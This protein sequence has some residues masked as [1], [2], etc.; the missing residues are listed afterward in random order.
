MNAMT[1]IKIDKNVPLVRH[2]GD[3]TRKYPFPD[4]EIGDSICIPHE[5]G[6]GARTAAANWGKYNGRKF[7][8][9]TTPEGLR[10]WR[11]A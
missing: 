7:S 3:G 5:K 4:M 10:I 6:E 8:S 1:E 11:V 9:R 2:S